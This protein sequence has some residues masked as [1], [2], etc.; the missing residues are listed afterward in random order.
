MSLMERIREKA[1]QNKMTIVLPEGSEPRTIAAAA[2][3]LEED[4]A[5]LVLLG[6]PG[7]IANS[8]TAGVDLSKATIIYP[9]SSPKLQA[10]ADAFYELRK[11]KGIR[12]AQAL[13]MVSDPL[14]YAV[15]MIREGDADG[16]VSGAVHS[17]GDTLRPALQVVKT[18]PGAQLVSSCFIMEV[19]N[20]S[21]GDDGVLV[22]A[23]CAINIDPDPEQLAAIAVETAHSARTIAGIE[24]R[25][26]MLS[27]S[28]KGSA[29]H[30]EVEKVQEATQIAHEMNPDLL[31]DGELQADAAL[32]STVGDLKCPGSPV[33]GHANVL[34]F[35]NLS[36]GNIGYK[37]VQRLAG[38]TAVGPICQGLA[39]PVNDLSRGC[40]VQDIVDVV[41]I[42][43]V[44]AQDFASLSAANKTP[45][46]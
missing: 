2:K 10:Y 11:S 28:T 18:A 41:A 12:P 5:N 27:F 6:N 44:Q 14:Y 34:I 19:P 23:D 29:K 36:A 32:V 24:P 43:A 17:T 13:E 21:Y 15:M 25:V 1:K 45:Q 22:F 35:P 38:A 26:A 8:N 4:I 31:L 20:K 39:R 9:P 7:E 33:A 40:S 30:P 37:L 3:I 42:T 46:A 16:M